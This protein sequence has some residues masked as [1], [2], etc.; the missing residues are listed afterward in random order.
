M[1]VFL[2][3]LIIASSVLA[4]TSDGFAP[5]QNSR[6]NRAQQSVTDGSHHDEVRRS[7]IASTLGALSFL[8]LASHAKDSKVRGR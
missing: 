1:K 4:F 7:V 8:P 3:K 5:Q 2:P 6:E